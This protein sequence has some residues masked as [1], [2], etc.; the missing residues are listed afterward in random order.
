MAAGIGP[1][2]ATLCLGTS[3]ALEV[4]ADAPLPWGGP[5]FS[6]LEPGQWVREA[7]IPTAGAAHRWFV[8][9]V[10]AGESYDLSDELAAVEPAADAPLFFPRLSDPSEH[11]WPHAPGG[12]MWGLG[13]GTNRADLARCVY[14]GVAFEVGDRWRRMGAEAETLRVFGGGA[15][16]EPWCRVIASVLG[17]PVERLHVAEASALGAAVSAGAPRMPLTS[18]GAPRRVRHGVGG[19]A[20]RALASHR[21]APRRRVRILDVRRSRECDNGPCRCRRLSRRPRVV[22][23]DMT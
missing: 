9:T 16:S 22:R 8:R 6:F 15:R 13:L 20:F 17:R 18:R 19:G 7:A 4:R 2:V 14:E 3:G 12:V 11:G 21:R 1:D 5:L 10:L 23:P